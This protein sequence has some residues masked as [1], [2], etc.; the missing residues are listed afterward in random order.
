LE[1][2]RV[3]AE[4][5]HQVEVFEAESHVGGQFMLRASISTWAEFEGVIDWRIEQ[6]AK[7]KVPV[8]LGRRIDS[9]DLEALEVEVLILATGA[10]PKNGPAIS[11]DASVRVTTP[12]DLIRSGVEDARRAVIWDRA[13]GVVANGA[14]DAALDLGLD[15]DIVTPQFMVAEDTDVVQRVPLYERLLSAGTRFHPNSEVIDATSGMVTLRNVYSFKET[16][17]GPVDL[18]IVWNGRQAQDGLQSHAD[19]LGL[20]THVIGDALAP[21]TAEFAIAEGAMLARRI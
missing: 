9:A 20:E 17:I 12:H 5:G 16:Q 21:R 8:H 11:G 3:A 14:M 2:A 7:L 10:V 4:R 13:G 19:A 6:L 15:L 18:M 1:A